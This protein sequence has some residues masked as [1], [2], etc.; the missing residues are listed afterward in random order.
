MRRPVLRRPPS[1]SACRATKDALGYVLKTVHLQHGGKLSL[2]RLLSGHL[3]DGATL[4]SSSGETGSISGILGVNGAH[5]T[6]RAA[7]EAGDT[8]ALAK[9]DTI[10]TGDTLSTGKTAPAGAGQGRAG[11]AGAVDLG[12]GGRPQGRRQARPGAVAAERGR[13]LADHGA[14]RADPRHRAVG[15]GRDASARGAGAAA[16]S[17]R[18][19]RQIASARDRLSR[20]HPQ[21]G[22]NQRGRHKKQS[23]GHGQ[24]GDVLLDIKPLPRG[25][26]FKFEEKVVGGAV[27]RNYIGAVEEGVGDATGARAARL[28]RGR[29]RR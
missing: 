15:A 10:K 22:H 8:V 3:D 11:A 2:T 18:R 27:P 26:G 4:Q 14:E 6:K 17:L 29:R 1:G 24:F 28:P 20:D 16:R 9:V 12:R 13:S 5:D 21:A 7:A 23:G 25:E 19:Q